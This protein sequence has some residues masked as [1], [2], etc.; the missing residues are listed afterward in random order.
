MG[1]APPLLDVRRAL[2]ALTT[3]S[4][5]SIPK[6][7][8]PM[9]DEITTRNPP[10]VRLQSPLN[11]DCNATDNCS[12]NTHKQ[13]TAVA[14]QYVYAI[15]K[16]SWRFPNDGVEREFVQIR[17]RVDTNGKADSEV[18]HAIFS[19]RQYRYLVR[20]LCWILS[21][22][23]MPAYV[24][25]PRDA[26]DF[27]LLV[28]ATRPNPARADFDVAIGRRGAL[29]AP[30]TSRGFEL[31]TLLLTQVY[32]FAQEA[33]IKSL[34]AR[35]DDHARVQY[36]N[37]ARGVFEQVA[38]LSDNIGGTDEDRALNYL[39]VRFAPLYDHTVALSR[40]QFSLASISRR[41]S[42]VSERRR[43]VDVILT[44]TSRVTGIDNRFLVRVDVTNEFPFLASKLMP[45]IET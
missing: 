39:S 41:S 31:P 8:Q 29:S 36:D 25:L 9:D 13:S 16:I 18:A 34:S 5:I 24:L 19:D 40:E 28:E 35:L 12:C 43:I 21:V 1:L 17:S 2:C 15:G 44:Y 37:V 20:E 32:S 7:N 22:E 42:T 38:S 33:L 14:P 45:F 3:R 10:V 27:D 30:E 11:C 23:G 6:R 26:A 4:V